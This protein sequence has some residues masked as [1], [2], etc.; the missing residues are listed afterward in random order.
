MFYFFIRLDLTENDLLP[1]LLHRN[2]PNPANEL[3][4]KG[5][6]FVRATSMSMMGCMRPAGRVFDIPSLEDL[7]EVMDDRHRWQERVR[8]EQ[9]DM[10]MITI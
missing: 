9:H 8:C 1:L 10:M 5:R 4:E 7:L 3:W 2:V 6:S